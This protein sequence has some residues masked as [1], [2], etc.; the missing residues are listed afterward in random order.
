M[1][2]LEQTLSA[3]RPVDWNLLPSIQRQLDALTK[4]KDSLGVLEDLARRICLIQGTLN[5]SLGKGRIYVFA[6]DHGVADEGVSAFPKAVTAQMIAN[7]AHGGAAINVLAKQSGAELCLVDIGVD[8]D[9]SYLTGVRH[10]KIRPGTRNMIH[11]P[12]MT[13][14]ETI[15]ALA[16][17]IRL[18]AEAAEQGIG[19]LGTG[20]MGIANTT[21]SAALMAA[22][23]PCT[24]T[25]IAGRGTGIDD[26]TLDKKK[27]VIE[28]SLDRHRDRLQDPILA[29]AAVGGLE[30]AGIAGVILGAAAHRMPIVVDGFISSA[31][32]LVACRAAPAVEDYLIFSHRSA[33][34]GHALFLEEM[35]ARPLLDLSMRLGEGTGAALALPVIAAGIAVFNEMARFDTAGVSNKTA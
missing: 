14:D 19:I 34:Q 35:G 20:D 3:I 22:L 31:G 30:I 21:A 9:V 27:K 7:M 16:V 1:N 13:K 26:D 12:A 15:R 18:A 5:P 29:L 28:R 8:A 2:D 24:A 32:A 17:G 6:A 10:E 25:D 4:P 33:E 23:L 11:E